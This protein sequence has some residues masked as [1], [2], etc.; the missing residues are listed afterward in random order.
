[1]GWDE[2]KA[3][4]MAEN[5]KDREKWV[6]AYI[7]AL[8]VLLAICTMG[9]AN[10]TKDATLNSVK[11]TNMWA[12]FQA[13]NLRRNGLTL[14]IDQLDLMIKANPAMPAAA[15]TDIE[16]KIAE[17]RATSDR[18]K[19]D[20]VT[21]EGL[22]ELFPAAKTLEQ[23][24]DLAM[25]RDPYFDFGQAF[26]QIAIVLA[27]VALIVAGWPLLIGSFSVAALG[28]VMMLNGFLLFAK[29]PFIEG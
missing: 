11:A 22:D 4:A 21:K 14:Q 17:Y 3:Q 18:L 6:G 23:E 16:K 2:L 8:A 10:S 20:P 9:G 25:R 24:R 28:V 1:M 7:G 27:S 26:I 5:H 13:K 15:K 12:F 19:S 29:I